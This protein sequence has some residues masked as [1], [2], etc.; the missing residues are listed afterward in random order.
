MNVETNIF[1]N[2]SLPSQFFWSHVTGTKD[3]FCLERKVYIDLTDN[4]DL[5]EHLTALWF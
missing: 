3:I 4:E 5:R 1:K 2:F